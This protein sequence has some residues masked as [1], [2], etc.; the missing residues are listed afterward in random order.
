MAQGQQ[1]GLPQQ[2]LLQ[3]AKG[4][5]FWLCASSNTSSN[6]TKESSLRSSSFSQTPCRAQGS[7]PLANTMLPTDSFFN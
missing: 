5:T 3:D 4:R 6:V 2:A 1:A 7:A